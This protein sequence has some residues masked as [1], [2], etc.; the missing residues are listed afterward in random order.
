MPSTG[1][2]WS[3]VRVRFLSPV[4]YVIAPVSAVAGSAPRHTGGIEDDRDGR[5]HVLGKPGLVDH[6]VERVAVADDLHAVGELGEP[7]RRLLAEQLRELAGW[8]ARHDLTGADVVA[9]AE[10]DRADLAPRQ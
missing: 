5:R 1:R 8:A 10:R 7:L 3:P 2:I 4:R 6:D 9:V